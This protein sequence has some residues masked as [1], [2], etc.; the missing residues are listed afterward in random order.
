MRVLSSPHFHRRR[1]PYRVI[2][3]KGF[4]GEPPLAVAARATSL[5]GQLQW[6]SR[7]CFGAIIAKPGSCGGLKRSCITTNRPLFVFL[8]VVQ[9]TAYSPCE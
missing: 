5:E 3:P 4:L 2:D 6:A 7:R 1:K 9:H 8:P